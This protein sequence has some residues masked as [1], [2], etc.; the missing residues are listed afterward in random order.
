MTPALSRL[1]TAGYHVLPWA[2]KADESCDN[3]A[4]RRE[5]AKRARPLEFRLACG[6]HRAAVDGNGWCL[7]FKRSAS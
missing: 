6:K 3:C 1:K 4:Y 2:M 7:H 5:V